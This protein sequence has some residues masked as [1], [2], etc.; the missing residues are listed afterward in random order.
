MKSKVS[1][2]KCNDYG[3]RNVYDAVEKAVDLLGGI[4]CFVKPGSRVLIKPNLL[5]AKPPDSGVDTHPEVLRSVIR[6]VKK[7]GGIIQVGDSPGGSVKKM[8]DVYTVSGTRKVCEEENVELINFDRIKMVQPRSAYRGGMKNIPIAKA[9]LEADVFIS[10]PK[11]KT[12]MLMTL[13]AGVKNVFGIVPGLSKTECHKSAPNPAAFAKLLVD[14]YSFAKPHLSILDGITGMEGDGPGTGGTL[15]KI[16]LIA[17]SAD[18]VSMDAVLA[19]IMG[20]KP[21]DIGTTREADRRKLGIGLMKK[22]E[23][24]GNNLKDFVQSDFKLPKTGIYHVIPNFM[25]RSL[26][27]FFKVKPDVIPDKC[28]HCGICVRSCPM[29]AISD[30][31]GRIRF[32]YKKCILCMCCHE[33]CPENAVFIRENLFNKIIRT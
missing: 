4:D 26:S 32:D 24:V 28:K 5:S 23:I 8:A 12:H 6:L 11:F 3:S 16:N 33:F 20:L 14:I 7:A 22:I 21:S 29:G 18:A 27:V 1:L 2:V 15:R 10:L 31:D 30:R 17:A 19:C 13:T 25:L 9:P